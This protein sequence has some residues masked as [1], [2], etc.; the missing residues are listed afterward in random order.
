MRAGLFHNASRSTVTRTLPSPIDRTEL[1]GG[2]FDQ[3]VA[4][5]RCVRIS[6]M[7]T[8]TSR[9]FMSSTS[10]VQLSTQSPSLQ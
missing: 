6:A 7:T 2:D 3:V 8:A 4:L 5:A 10:A 9:P 1:S